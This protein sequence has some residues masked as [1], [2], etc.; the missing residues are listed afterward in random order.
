DTGDAAGTRGADAD[1]GG[2]SRRCAADADADIAGAGAA[3]ERGG[4]GSASDAAACAAGAGVAAGQRRACA[5]PVAPVA[6]HHA[7]SRWKRPGPEC[8]AAD[9]AGRGA[10]GNGGAA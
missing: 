6:S 7:A 3:T 2:G 10:G 8:A 5:E 1:T 4:D 9:L